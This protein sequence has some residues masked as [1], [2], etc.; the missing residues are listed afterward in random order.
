MVIIPT[1]ASKSFLFAT[2]KCML[3]IL[4]LMHPFL[5]LPPKQISL[6]RQRHQKIV[7]GFSIL[8]TIL[9]HLMHGSIQKYQPGSGPHDLTAGI[10]ICILF[11]YAQS[12]HLRAFHY[13]WF[14][15]RK[16]P[17]FKAP[18]CLL[19]LGHQC[20]QS[21]TLGSVLSFT[22]NVRKYSQRQ[23]GRG[24]KAKAIYTHKIMLCTF[25]YIFYLTIY[26]FFNYRFPYNNLE[27]LTMQV[28]F[29]KGSMSNRS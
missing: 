24:R 10:S 7:I 23:T 17:L 2:D 27:V 29:I 15:K 9:Y 5:P 20:W 8:T 1:F 28:T 4:L 14:C 21:T 13:N 26:I 19:I 25:T 18:F 6:C 16:Q 22:G 3:Q 12:H 11:C